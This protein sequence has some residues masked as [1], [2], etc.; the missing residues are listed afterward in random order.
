M[1]EIATIEWV[2]I[3][4]ELLTPLITVYFTSQLVRN[5]NHREFRYKEGNLKL[6]F[7]N[8]LVQAGAQQG[9]LQSIASMLRVKNPS[10]KELILEAYQELYAEQFGSGVRWPTPDAFRNLMK[11]YEPNENW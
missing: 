1:A 6:V 10:K 7:K 4:I 3:A 2:K 11:N 9:L 8:N 5:D